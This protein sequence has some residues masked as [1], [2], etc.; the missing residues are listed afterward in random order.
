MPRVGS[1]ASAP[2]GSMRPEGIFPAATTLPSALWATP[3]V[4][5]LEPP[6]TATDPLGPSNA[7]TTRDATAEVIENRRSAPTKDLLVVM[8]E[9]FSGEAAIP[10]CGTGPRRP[11]G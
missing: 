9:R 3:R 8:R 10:S 5:E 2:T 4:L 1:I 6:A 7:A 11:T